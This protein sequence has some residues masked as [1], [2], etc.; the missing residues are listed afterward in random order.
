M[1]DSLV[2]ANPPRELDSEN[3]EDDVNEVTESRIDDSTPPPPTTA[4][5]DAAVEITDETIEETLELTT[6]IPTTV[7]E[8][9][10]VSEP[11][12]T[13]ATTKTKEAITTSTAEPSTT[14]IIVE[15]VE[16]RNEQLGTIAAPE[17]PES[18][19][20][21]EEPLVVENDNDVLRRVQPARMRIMKSD[22][23]SECGKTLVEA[24]KGESGWDRV[25]N[26]FRSNCH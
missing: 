21:M 24:V 2:R 13:T 4:S 26:G 5:A 11:L 3:N 25:E 6:E 23:V 1:K 16:T 12:T 7:K 18:V 22:L 10:E 14:P 20:S 17:S 9:E 8:E 15:L 19:E